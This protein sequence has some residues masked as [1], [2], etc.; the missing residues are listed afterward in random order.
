MIICQ[1]K[2]KK[3]HNLSAALPENI[4]E[5]THKCP[6]QPKNRWTANIYSQPFSYSRI[7]DR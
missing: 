4:T 6:S 3:T 5:N 2:T 1:S 7:Q